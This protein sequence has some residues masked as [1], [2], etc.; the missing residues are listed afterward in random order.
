M[1]IF[2]DRTIRKISL[3]SVLFLAAPS[4]MAASIQ[5]QG[6]LQVSDYS[7]PPLGN[8]LGL[9]IL[10]YNNLDQGMATAT[11]ING[12]NSLNIEPAEL[13][14]NFLNFELADVVYGPGSAT[15]IYADLDNDG[16]FAFLSNGTAIA[17]ATDF[18]SNVT[19][20]WLSTPPF[21]HVSGQGQVTLTGPTNS[22]FYQEVLELTDGTGILHYTIDEFIPPLVLHQ[23]PA[24]ISIEVTYSTAPIP[25][26]LWMFGSALLALAG[27]RSRRLGS[28]RG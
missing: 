12:F 25:S 7:G 22:A 2:K 26:A 4:V 3:S 27:F 9:D 23:D 20:T 14:N 18:V 24:T 8:L 1:R 6:T 10:A 19:T 17:S 28:L 11:S 21:A 5:M 15:E 13:S 16:S